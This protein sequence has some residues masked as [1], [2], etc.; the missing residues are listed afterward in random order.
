MT[1]TAT[2]E[3]D[4]ILAAQRVL[5]SDIL[6]DLSRVLAVLDP[7]GS[8][9]HVTNRFSE[10]TGQS[11]DESLGQGYL[12][13]VHPEDVLTVATSCTAAVNQ[14]RGI[15]VHYRLVHKHSREIIHMVGLAQPLYNDDGRFAGTILRCA[16]L[17]TKS[18][19]EQIH[20]TSTPLVVSLDTNLHVLS[21]NG[22]ASGILGDPEGI[23]GRCVLDFV[24]PDDADLAITGLYD[25]LS[26]LNPV[27]PIVVR[28]FDRDGTT[29]HIEAYAR[30]LT[31]LALVGG[32]LIDARDV[33]DQVDQ[34]AKMSQKIER[35]SQILE[36]LAEGVCV[37]DD[38]GSTTYVNAALCA[39]LDI[40]ADELLGNS[41]LD[42]I[43]PVH[44]WIAA[45][46]F[47]I[48]DNYPT[49]RLPLVLRPR[50]QKPLV[51]EVTCAPLSTGGYVATIVDVSAKMHAQEATV[52][53]KSA[54]ESADQVKATLLSRVSHELRTPLHAILGYTDLLRSQV[55]ET[56]EHYL[57]QLETATRHLRT[58]IDDVLDI[59]TSDSASL[60][61]HVETLNADLVIQDAIA[62]VAP[63]ADSHHTEILTI[64]RDN[65][66]ISTDR[67]RLGQ[68]LANLLSNAVK[69]SPPVSTI[70]INCVEIAGCVEF[71][72]TDA[73][74]GV[75]PAEALT[76]FQ[77]FFRGSASKNVP[78]S[79]L[80]LTVVASLASALGANVRVVGNTFTFALPTLNQIS[81]TELPVPPSAPSPFIKVVQIDDDPVAALLLAELSIDSD[82]VVRHAATGHDGHAMIASGRPDVVLLDLSLPDTTGQKILSTIRANE[83]LAS[84]PIIITT[85]D[86]R[87][88]TE[89]EL[90]SLG[91]QGYLVKPF[92]LRDLPALL[93]AVVNNE[94]AT[95]PA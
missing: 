27:G 25:V 41:C 93:H 45:S 9:V 78:G 49:E 10:L 55:P 65:P 19:Y 64:A 38:Q 7:T 8:L 73:G 35:A 15:G 82:F 43:D 29:R 86:A 30:N 44:H 24:H 47:R 62:L 36:Q 2:N 20:Q 76:I 90:R 32:I 72:V 74:P 11:R 13:C 77:P 54:L 71:R 31:E 39:M 83:Q 89:E 51:T 50:D 69:Y 4:T 63:L 42:F 81:G 26:S 1:T 23:L 60:S 95:Q 61:L 3:H 37:I 88:S 59:T 56:A 52:L 34:A 85:A 84:L 46:S 12:L 92:P 40:P 70:T 68:A 48:L 17:L 22:A 53:A 18:T 75:E 16:E 58:L 91:V 94:F 79:G 5:D 14:R 33:T 21:M 80:G 57:T 87:P 28:M 67:Q 6:D 66:L